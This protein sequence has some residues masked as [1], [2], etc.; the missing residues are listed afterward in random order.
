MRGR[1]N[2]KSMKSSDMCTCKSGEGL[3]GLILIVFGIYQMDGMISS[4]TILGDTQVTV[5]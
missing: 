2:M 3:F 4:T 1:K 5:V